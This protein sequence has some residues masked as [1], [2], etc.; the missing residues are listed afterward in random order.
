MADSGR[1]RYATQLRVLRKQQR[2]T[3]SLADRMKFLTE[4]M[5]LKWLVEITLF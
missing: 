2:R 3:G 1:L 5:G 4:A